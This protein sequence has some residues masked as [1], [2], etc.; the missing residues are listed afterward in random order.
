MPGLRRKQMTVLRW[1]NHRIHHHPVSRLLLTYCKK[2]AIQRKIKRKM[3]FFRKKSA[4]SSSSECFS[5]FDVENGKIF[6]SPS[7]SKSCMDLISG[8]YIIEKQGGN[9]RKK[10]VFNGFFH[11]S[12]RAA[13]MMRLSLRLLARKIIQTVLHL[14]LGL[15]GLIPLFPCSGKTSRKRWRG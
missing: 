14:P 4:F 13:A 7:Y 5:A 2:G 1:K 12:S 11:H 10:Q 6:P 15:R 8:K 9:Q 3:F